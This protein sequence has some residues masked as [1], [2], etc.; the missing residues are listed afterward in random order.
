MR[1]RSQPPEREQGADIKAEERNRHNL[2]VRIAKKG[3]QIIQ[4]GLTVS[5][6]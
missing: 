5:E 4:V 2:K 1:F 3:L 6:S